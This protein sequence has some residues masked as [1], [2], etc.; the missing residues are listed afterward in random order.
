MVIRGTHLGSGTQHGS[1]IVDF[2]LKFNLTSFLEL[3][4]PTD[5]DSGS[6]QDQSRIGEAVRAG[7]TG[8]RSDSKLKVKRYQ[9]GSS[10]GSPKQLSREERNMSALELWVKKFCD[11]KAE[12]RR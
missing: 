11:D 4:S 7:A 2:E 10:N 12:N 9:H 8:R 5:D 6:G 3:S 1:T